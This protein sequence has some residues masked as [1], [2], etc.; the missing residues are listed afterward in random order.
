[1]AEPQTQQQ[2]GGGDPTPQPEGAD[3]AANLPDD[4]NDQTKSLP[5][6]ELPKFFNSVAEKMESKELPDAERIVSKL[7]NEWASLVRATEDPSASARREIYNQWC[8]LE[9]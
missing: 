2:Q 9:T 4:I 8:V 3:A 5:Y 7:S 6:G 1:M